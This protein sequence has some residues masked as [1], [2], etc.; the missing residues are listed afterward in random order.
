MGQKQTS[1]GSRGG[2]EKEKRKKKILGSERVVVYDV[3][4]VGYG[5]E[6]IDKVQQ[7]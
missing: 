1:H 5:Q 3:K 4:K 7:A 2:T 6:T